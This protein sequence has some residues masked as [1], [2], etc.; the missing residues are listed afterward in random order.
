MAKASE[1]K[2]DTFL[3]MLVVGDSGTGKTGALLSLIQAGYN[4]RMLDFDAGAESL[5]QLINRHCPERIDQF[6][7]IQLR[8]NF[9][10]DPQLGAKPKGVPVAY[11][12][13][14]K[15]LNKWDDDSTPSEWGHKTIFVLDTLTTFGRAAFLWAQAMN[16]Q[17]NSGKRAN[18]LQW[19][20]TAQDSIRNVLDLLTSRQ[21][22]AHVLILS[23][24]QLVEMDEGVNQLQVTAIG[25]ALGA[26]L[27]KIF[28]NMV[29][30]TKTGSGDN[31]K[32]TIQTVPTPLLDLKT[33]APWLLER[34]LPLETGLATIFE[35][36]L[37]VAGEDSK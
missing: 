24:L 9:V 30:V 37:P 31:V 22:H 12:R 3:R 13:G 18:G 32:R 5:V 25:K 29:Q 14:V 2:A 34:R 23:H 28:N 4:I 8:D 35:Q 1:Q 21:F 10:P 26:D 27:P 11:T 33:V 17:S 6:D 36:L 16:P 7:Y 20:G 19:Y 15:F